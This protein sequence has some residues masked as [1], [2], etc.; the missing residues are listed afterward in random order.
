[1][2]KK[3]TNLRLSEE[4]YEA[5]VG[6]CRQ[7]RVT[8]VALLD[9][10]GPWLANEASDATRQ[11]LIDRAR[12]RVSERYMA[13]SALRQATIAEKKAEMEGDY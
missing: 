3:A 2:G 4:A 6:L 8:L 13:G 11:R 10:M 1:M 9:V 5:L 7:H 12:A